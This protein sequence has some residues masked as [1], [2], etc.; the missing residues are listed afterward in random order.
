MFSDPAMSMIIIS[1]FAGI[2]H[3]IYCDLT[4]DIYRND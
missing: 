4:H 1:T 2:A 3:D